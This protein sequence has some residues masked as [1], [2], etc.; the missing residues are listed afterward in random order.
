MA[1]ARRKAQSGLDQMRESVKLP[2]MGFECYGDARQTA[3]SLFV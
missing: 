1:V 2:L 3:T